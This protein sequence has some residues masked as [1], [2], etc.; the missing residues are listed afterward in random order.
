MLWQKVEK[1]HHQKLTEMMM[2]EQCL[3]N[4]VSDAS[5]NEISEHLVRM[6]IDQQ[7]GRREQ[8]ANLYLRWIIHQST[9]EDQEECGQL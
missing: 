9:V 1:Y 2:S 7:T 3:G 8:I 5:Y 6:R 4:G